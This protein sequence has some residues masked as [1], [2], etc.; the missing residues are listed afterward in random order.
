MNEEKETTQDNELFKLSDNYLMARQAKE[1]YERLAKEYGAVCDEHEQ[2]LIEAMIGNEVT[3]FKREGTQITLYNKT[4]ISA[5]PER[6]DELWSA[7]KGQGYEHL[8]SI[9]ANTLSGE[10]KRLMEENNGEVP[11]WLEGLVKQF[12]KPGLRVKR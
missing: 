8:F 3:S 9:N 10:V 7:M 12:D 6:K 5:E 11:K 2:K 4:H 1:E